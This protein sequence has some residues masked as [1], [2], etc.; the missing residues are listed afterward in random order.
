[1]QKTEITAPLRRI[2]LRSF[3]LAGAA[4]VLAACGSSAS[5]VGKSKAQ[6]KPKPTPAPASTP[7]TSKGIGL[8]RPARGSIIARFDGNRNKGIDIAG[9]AGDPILAAADG[10]VV[11]AGSDLRGYGGLV[12]VKHNNTFISAYAHNQAILV[13]EKEVVRQGQV[14]AQMGDTGTD[15]VKLHFEL[16]KEGNAVDPEPYFQR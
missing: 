10:R 14:I 11:Y 3:F 12:I 8:I 9:R 16:R 7:A 1:M 4:A 5:R 15:R 13:R 6:P 2:A